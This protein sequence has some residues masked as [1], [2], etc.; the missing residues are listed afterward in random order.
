MND[1]KPTS[2]SDPVRVAVVGGGLSG[3]MCARTLGDHGVH[4]VVFDKARGPGGRMSTRR[5]AAGW[6]FDHGAQYFTAEDAGLQRC[7]ASWRGDGIVDVWRGRLVRLEGGRPAPVHDGKIRYVGTPTMSRVCKQLA[8]ALDYRPR[9]LVTAMKRR[10]ERCVVEIDGKGEAGPFHAAV[11][12]IPAPQVMGLL[13]AGDPVAARVRHVRMHPTWAMMLGFDQPLGLDFDAAFVD[14]SSV[15]WVM[16]N[17]SKPGRDL[18]KPRECW[19]I[20]AAH[21]WSE[22]NLE[23]D[24]SSVARDMLQELQRVLPHPIPDP[25]HVD[26]HCW[27]YA[28]AATPLGEPSL[29]DSSRALSVCGDWCLGTR[30]E[31]AF[32]SGVAAAEQIVRRVLPASRMA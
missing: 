6:S 32:T 1:G 7:L 8:G 10:E 3:L 27:R 28:V 15:V 11:L 31:A 4:S 20:H 23:A 21:Q 25:Q 24:A 13:G 9:H 30:V 29:F 5:A 12:A 2:T 19:T 26:V 14:E 16:R 17:G 18:E 22:Q